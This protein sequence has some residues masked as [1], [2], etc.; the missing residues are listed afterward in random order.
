[1]A[2][3]S[4]GNGGLTPVLP[5]GMLRMFHGWIQ[6]ELVTKSKAAIK[7]R[8]AGEGGSTLAFF[9]EVSRRLASNAATAAG[10]GSSR[11]S[12]VRRY[13]CQHAKPADRPAHQ[14]HQ[15]AIRSK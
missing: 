3:G 14:S 9:S 4:W 2:A 6:A 10:G 1:M 12:Q 11:A 5:N 15:P 7:L 8:P 13:L